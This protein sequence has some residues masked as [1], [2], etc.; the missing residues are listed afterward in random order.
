MFSFPNGPLGWAPI[1]RGIHLVPHEL[2][3]RSPRHRISVPCK[4]D[5]RAIFQLVEAPLP[6][7]V[8]TSTPS[9]EVSAR[10]VLP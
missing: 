5:L 6:K 2:D 1:W 4:I 9:Q 10:P 7:E 8:L 3:R